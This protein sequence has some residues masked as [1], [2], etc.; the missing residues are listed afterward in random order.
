M[1]MTITPLFEPFIRKIQPDNYLDKLTVHFTTKNIISKEKTLT[2]TGKEAEIEQGFIN[3]NENITF[4]MEPETFENIVK[5][6]SDKKEVIIEK[7]PSKNRRR[8]NSLL[9]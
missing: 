3:Y 1:K 5:A 9:L 6:M 4:K 7:D 8:K 2:K